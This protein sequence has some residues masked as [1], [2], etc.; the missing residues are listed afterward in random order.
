MLKNNPQHHI[1]EM[2]KQFPIVRHLDSTRFFVLANL[3]SIIGLPR[4]AGL[5]K[6]WAAIESND[7]ELAANE[8]LESKWG[9]QSNGSAVEWAILMKSGI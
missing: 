5:K 3:A 7:Y 2:V 9:R 6:M 8:L 1:S 4:L